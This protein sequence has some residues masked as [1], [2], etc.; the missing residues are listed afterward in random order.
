MSNEVVAYADRKAE[1]GKRTDE[2]LGHPSICI[3]LLVNQKSFT[4]PCA[5]SSLS[6]MRG[7][8][9]PRQ[10]SSPHNAFQAQL[11]KQHWQVFLFH[12]N[13][14]MIKRVNLDP[15]LCLLRHFLK[16]KAKPISAITTFLHLST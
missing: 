12:L 11:L 13:H 10:P 8:K 1:A 6:K 2:S 15:C 16:C 14:A 9:C 7:I 3:C 4:V 5:S